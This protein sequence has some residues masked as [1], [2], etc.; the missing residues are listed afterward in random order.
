MIE[1]SKKHIPTIDE[2]IASYKN[3]NSEMLL[4]LRDLLNE[5]IAEYENKNKIIK[6]LRT[7]AN[8]NVKIYRNNGDIIAALAWQDFVAETYGE[9]SLLNDEEWKGKP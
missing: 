7:M 1:S 9:S 3:P 4:P 2:K 8:E 6:F 5:V